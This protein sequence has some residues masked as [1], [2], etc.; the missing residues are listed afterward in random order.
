V[1]ALI[2]HDATLTPAGRW[3]Y[4]DAAAREIFAQLRFDLPKRDPDTDKPEKTFRLMRKSEAGWTWGKPKGLLPLY[5][6]PDVLARQ[7]K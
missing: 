5:R 2:A 1:R 3:I 7:E 4:S 6:L